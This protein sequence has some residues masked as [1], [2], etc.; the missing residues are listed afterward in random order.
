MP[1]TQGIKLLKAASLGLPAE[2]VLISIVIMAVL[3]VACVTVA[4]RFF[5][6]E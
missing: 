3:T 6:W 2:N 5:R 1:L 4:L